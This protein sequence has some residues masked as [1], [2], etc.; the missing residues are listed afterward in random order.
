ML[1]SKFYKQIVRCSMGGPFSVIFFHIYMTK[2]K[3]KVV[4]LTKPQFYKRFVD[5]I[6]N[7]RYKDQPDNLF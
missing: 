3:R 5:D 4:E 1:N 2:T 7:K 6:I